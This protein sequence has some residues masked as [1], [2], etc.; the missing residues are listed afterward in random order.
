MKIIADKIVSG[1]NCI[2]KNEGKTVFIPGALPGETLDIEIIQQKK[3][4]DIGK[5]ISILQ[6]NKNRVTPK[7]SYYGICG[8]CN[9]Q[10][11]SDSYQRELKVEILND[12]F[13][14]TL[15]RTGFHFPKIELIAGQSWEYRCRYQ[16]SEGGLKKREGKD[17]VAIDDCLIATQPIREFLQSKNK[18]PGFLTSEREHL[19]ADSRCEKPTEIYTANNNSLCTVN[20]QN[21]KLTF[22]T[23][24]FFQSNLEML[25]KTI[26]LVFKNFTGEK[27][28]DMYCGV[29]TFSVFAKEY[30]NEL[31]LVEHNKAAIEFA[32]SNLETNR[33]SIKNCS[34]YGLSGEKWVK[35][36]GKNMVFDGIVIDPPRT[37]IEKPVLEWIS[38][39]NTPVIKYISCDPTTQARDA[40][41]LLEAG[42]HMTEL[43]LLDFYP[44]SSH[45]ETLACFVKK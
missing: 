31:T 39:S 34:F 44:Q 1:G 23:K 3:D 36:K 12:I 29:G 17:T 6:Q 25:E 18:S 15:S 14:R 30:F 8:G 16:F 38:N 20:I 24:G 28:L 5:I 26:P 43:Y 45:I 33:T 37:G 21:H 11:A 27:L 2:G 19:F 42:Y 22:D 41:V 40:K 13:S 10:I 4:Y 35:I 9:L 32:K 7:C